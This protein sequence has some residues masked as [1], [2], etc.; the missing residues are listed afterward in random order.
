[1]DQVR[2]FLNVVWVQR[3][4]VL[5]V[6]GVLVAAV[7]WMMAAGALDQEFASNKSSIEGKFGDMNKI[8]E[9]PVHGNDEVNNQEIQQAVLI[10]N[11]VSD[12]W[13]QLYDRQRD[14]VLKWPDDLGEPFLEYVEGKKFKDPITRPDML[15]IYRNY[16]ANRFDG[17]VEIVD[18][19]KMAEGEFGAIGR[20]GE[21]GG[22]DEFGRGRYDEGRG[23][24]DGGRGGFGTD[25]VDQFGNPI[26]DDYLVEW[27]DQGALR[28]KLEFPQR[29]TSLQVWVTQE[30]LWVYETLLN[31]IAATNEARQATRPDNTAIRWIEQLQ[32]GEAAALAS[33]QRGN[34][35]LPASATADASLEYTGGVGREDYS[36]DGGGAGA[37]PDAVLLRNRYIGEDGKP[38]ADDTGN[39]GTEYRCLPVRMVLYMDQRWLPTILTECANAPLPVE[40]KR[41]RINSEQ[42]G[43]EF[44]N[45]LANLGAAAE[46]TY[47][48]G[49]GDEGGRGGYGGYDGGR[50]GYGGIEGGRGGGTL[51][52]AGG[53]GPEM[54]TVEIQ[55]LVYIYNQPD[56]AALTVPGGDEA[57]AAAE[58]PVAAAEAVTR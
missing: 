12:L 10:R 7:C 52:T 14:T 44:G 26:D 24:Y 45:E 18:A 53:A 23:G 43:G 48:G 54:A 41:I 13:R 31:A 19:K 20:G 42:S 25:G 2:A 32:V 49:R 30:D 38:I 5:S 39:F 29:P 56:P 6:V 1:M 47:S 50:G 36:T 15:D 11:K 34:V 22:G 58:T 9:A 17:L 35:M 51:P 4:W 8:N 16:I 27:L 55:G 46:P 37:N 40:V 28:A 3:F 33:T 57:L 21:F